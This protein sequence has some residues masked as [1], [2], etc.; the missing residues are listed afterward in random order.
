MP[1]RLS[2]AKRPRDVNQLMHHL[3]EQSTREKEPEKAK[4]PTKAEISRAVLEAPVVEVERPLG[5][6]PHH[7]PGANTFLNEFAD[8]Y[9]L[10]FE[11][12]RGGAETMYP[13]Y[14]QK[15]SGTPAKTATR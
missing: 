13:E 15:I 10:P 4:A 11:A 9:K 6:V 2:K 5:A 1:K 7:L 3:G 12:T 8:K 14:V